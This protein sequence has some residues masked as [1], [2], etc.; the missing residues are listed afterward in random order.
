MEITSLE[1]FMFQVHLL[2][3]GHC[4]SHIHDVSWSRLENT[5]PE[6]TDLIQT[7]QHR[8]KFNPDNNVK[9]NKY[10]YG[11]T[12]TQI[13]KESKTPENLFNQH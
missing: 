11:K 13:E 2:F 9:I 1:R 10:Y 7:V 4:Y 12:K 8:M 3:K 6:Y 5:Q